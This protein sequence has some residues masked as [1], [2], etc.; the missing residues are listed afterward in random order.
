MMRKP[1]SWALLALAFPACSPSSPAVSTQN[2][3]AG[4]GISGSAPGNGS[5]SGS[6]T[7]TGTDAAANG[8]DDSGGGSED[9]A[10]AADRGSSGDDGGTDRA[11]GVGSGDGGSCAGLVCEDFERGQGQLDTTK[12]DLQIG[13]GGMAMIQQ[14][15]VAHG[16]Y[17]WQV[18]GTGNRFDFATILTKNTP[19]APQGA[20]P[21]YARAYV[22]APTNYGTHIQLGLAG[23]TGNPAVPP[24]IKLGGTNFNYMEFAEFANSWQLGFDLFSAAFGFQAEEASYP[25]ARDMYPTKAW[26]CIEWEFGDNPDMMVLWVDGKQIDQLDAQHIGFSTGSHA[27]GSVYNGKTSGIIG[28]YTV[29]GFG[30]HSWGASGVVDRYYDDIVLDTK[31]VNCLP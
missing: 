22:Y 25:P 4:N 14:N 19:M 10:T 20:G 18:H 17:A 24:M 28:G 6:G 1:C 2:I 29:F 3:D 23:T 13:G 8:G 7:G 30:F 31:R 16:K 9:G 26:N 21:F 27:G 5:G 12:W 15:V 11:P